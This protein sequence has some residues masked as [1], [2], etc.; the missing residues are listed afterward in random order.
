MADHWFA[1]SKKIKALLIII[2]L[3]MIPLVLKFITLNDLEK[4]PTICVF[5]NI[6][7]RDCWG[8]GT[9]R[10]VVSMLNLEFKQAY[11][12]NKRIV[13]VFPLL[14][15]LWIKSIYHNIKILLKKKPITTDLSYS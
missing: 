13:I 9:S 2:I 4:A 15:Y 10:A 12:F 11:E 1:D 8:C 14:V 7:G 3:V 6:T 5:K